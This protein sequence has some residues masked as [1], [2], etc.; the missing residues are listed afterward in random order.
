MTTVQFKLGGTLQFVEDEP[1]LAGAFVTL[2]YEGFTVTARGE[3]MSYKLPNDHVV[4]VKVAYQDAKGNIAA[5]DGEVI[6][7][8]SN[9]S[10]AAVEPDSKDSSMATVRPGLNIGQ[11]QISAT[12]DADLG[13]GVHELITILDVEIVAGEAVTGTIVP[14]G[15]PQPITPTPT[16]RRR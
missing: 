7:E 2:C 14:V 6:W 4:V 13:E 10:I 1:S 9:D 3:A 11:V 8:T 12:A 15:E 16:P 5:V